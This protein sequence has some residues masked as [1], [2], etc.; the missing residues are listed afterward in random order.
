MS[1]FTDAKELDEV[2]DDTPWDVVIRCVSVVTFIVYLLQGVIDYVLPGKS[3]AWI[4][5]ILSPVTLCAGT[6]WLCVMIIGALSTLKKGL[7]RWMN[8]EQ[9]EPCSVE[10]N[11]SEQTPLSDAV[12]H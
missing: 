12:I 7:Y 11:R 4:E 5:I 10:P 9:P 3:C 1:E 6:F 8:I 2:L